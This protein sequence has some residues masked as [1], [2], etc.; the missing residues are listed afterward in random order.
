MSEQ[1][2]SAPISLACVLQMW[3]PDDDDEEQPWRSFT[4]EITAFCDDDPHQRPIG[5][6][7]GVLTFS[8]DAEL[9]RAADAMSD[10][11][12]TL[13]VAAEQVLWDEMETVD[14]VM[15]LEMAVLEKP[16][17]GQGLAWEC[18]AE[19]LRTV[20]ARTA[21]VTLQPNRS[22]KAAGR[23]RM[24]T[25]GGQRWSVFAR[26]G[27]ATGSTPAMMACPCGVVTG[28][29]AHDGCREASGSGVPKFDAVGLSRCSS[30]RPTRSFSDSG[31]LRWL[32]WQ[33]HCTP[34]LHLC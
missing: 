9:A 12:A 14:T 17:R 2:S 30:G 26:R 6:L 31:A 21:L 8:P 29:M 1:R 27:P 22:E 28:A 5:H 18:I 33:L 24:M 23:S 20:D 10:E 7:R 11:S 34:S 3:V 25:F 4:A 32:P 13:A 19:V 16:F 15:L